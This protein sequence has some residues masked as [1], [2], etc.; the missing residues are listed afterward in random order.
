[1]FRHFPCG[2]LEDWSPSVSTNAIHA[3]FNIL[4]T[5][6][7]EL[8]LSTLNLLFCHKLSFCPVLLVL[9]YELQFEAYKDISLLKY[10][11]SLYINHIFGQY[12]SVQVLAL[13]CLFL[14]YLYVPCLILAMSCV[15]TLNL[16]IYFNLMYAQILPYLCTVSIVKW[17]STLL[18]YIS[19]FIWLI[20]WETVFHVPME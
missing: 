18:L 8:I 11:L 1:M 16:G 6:L 19:I 9:K 15:C 3:T 20:I 4:A 17:F 14:Y 12:P 13:N 10:R 7:Y 2:T 5:C